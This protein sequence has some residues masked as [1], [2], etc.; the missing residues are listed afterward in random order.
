[1]FTDRTYVFSVF[2]SYLFSFII[3]CDFVEKISND[4][5]ENR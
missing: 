1:V 3:V 2:A 4:I 5:S